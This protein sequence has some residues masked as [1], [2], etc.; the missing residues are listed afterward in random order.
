[1][2]LGIIK[3]SGGNGVHQ[4]E[5][6]SGR[7]FGMGGYVRLLNSCLLSLCFF[8]IQ[9]A[10]GTPEVAGAVQPVSGGKVERQFSL[11][12]VP[13]HDPLLKKAK[14][15]FVGRFN[16]GEFSPEIAEVFDRFLKSCHQFNESKNA[17]EKCLDNYALQKDPQTKQE[18]LRAC[19]DFVNDATV[20]AGNSED[21]AYQ[22]DF[23][24]QLR[25][26]ISEN[27][28][29]L[30]KKAHNLREVCISQNTANNSQWVQD[31][32]RQFFDVSSVG[33]NTQ[34]LIGKLYLIQLEITEKREFRSKLLYATLALGLVGFGYLAFKPE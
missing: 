9:P 5:I 32:H 12:D 2:G 16:S 14:N 10:I 11:S 4:K 33:E 34:R 15:D 24:V 3:T 25:N 7:D 31:V 13:V 8:A 20:V 6:T 29:N 30:R 27:A 21:L 18:L 28:Q 23:E 17:V 19:I 26:K 1:M 22:L